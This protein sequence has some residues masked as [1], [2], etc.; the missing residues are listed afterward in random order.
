MSKSSD[1]VQTSL[2]AIT[3]TA[4]GCGIGLLI[5]VDAIPDTFATALNVTGDLAAVAIVARTREP[6]ADALAAP[7]AA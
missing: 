3:Q 1:P 5:A 4:V 6:A 2:L 7:A